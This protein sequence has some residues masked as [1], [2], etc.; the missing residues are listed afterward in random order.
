ML[1]DSP[2]CSCF[3]EQVHHAPIAGFWVWSSPAL[4]PNFLKSAF[5]WEHVWGLASLLPPLL[6]GPKEH[7]RRPG[8][9]QPGSM[10][11]HASP[12][13][14][15]HTLGRGHGSARVWEDKREPLLLQRKSELISHLCCVQSP[16]TISPS[17]VS[18]S[19]WLKTFNLL[20]IQNT[21]LAHH[22]YESLE[23]GHWLQKQSLEPT[24]AADEEVSSPFPGKTVEPERNCTHDPLHLSLPQQRKHFLQSVTSEAL[25]EMSFK[26]WKEI[27]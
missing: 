9:H 15:P 6:V 18:P 7:P 5:V 26:F 22:L 19:F 14:F 24:A 21:A 1:P 20:D 23:K 8:S 3:R 13:A 10:S 16:A 11:P 2:S 12:T 27:I 17:H 25:M 4:R